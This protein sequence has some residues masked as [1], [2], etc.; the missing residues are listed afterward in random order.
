MEI[1]TLEGLG[2]L[3][4]VLTALVRVLFTKVSDALSTQGELLLTDAM[5]Q[6]LT[7]AK[8]KEEVA[9]RYLVCGEAYTLVRD[10][11]A[12][13]LRGVDSE[14]F[15]QMLEGAR[16]VT[17]T[18]LERSDQTKTGHILGA[19]AKRG[20]EA[21]PE[22]DL[23]PLE[24][25]I[26]RLFTHAA[27][28]LGASVQGQTLEKAVADGNK[29]IVAD[30][31]QGKN[32][33]LNVVYEVQDESADEGDGLKQLHTS[34]AV[35]CYR[36]RITIDHFFRQFQSQVEA[37]VDMKDKFKVIRLFK[38]ESPTLRAL[39]YLPAILDG[40]KRLMNQ[41]HRQKDR[42]E[43][44]ALTIKMVKERKDCTGLDELLE[45]V[46]KAWDIVKDRLITYNCLAP[47]K[48][49][50][51]LPPEF[52]DTSIS[53]NSPLAVLLPSTRGP[54]LC[55]YILLQYLLAAHNHILEGYCPLL[56][57]SDADHTN[58]YKRL[59]EVPVRKISARHLV[60]YSPEGILPLL[61]SSCNYSLQLGHTTTMEYDFEGFQK[62][63]VDTVFQCKSRVQRH[64]DGYFPEALTPAERRE[65]RDDLF[66]D[67]PH[68][69]ESIDHLNTALAFLKA[70]GGDPEGSLHEFMARSL[71]MEQTIHSRKAQQLC[72]LKHVQ[73]LWIL[74]CHERATVLAT[75]NQ[76]A[77][78]EQ[79][80][81]LREPMTEAQEKEL[82]AMCDAMSVDRLELLLVHL[83]ECIM[84][85]LS[86]PPDD[87]FYVEPEDFNLF[88]ELETDLRDVPFYAK[89]PVE[90]QT[91][92]LTADDLTTFKFPKS[93]EG[94]HSTSVWLA[95]RKYLAAKRQELNVATHP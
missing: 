74:L 76:D 9:D 83:F 8:Q 73:S 3:R 56:R 41:L 71:Q 84:L 23:T 70:L 86:Q 60:G 43:A 67:L 35:W 61:L 13:V 14:Q 19:A 7:L 4:Y 52:H 30:K 51:S 47:E 75:Y 94:R 82:K 92:L 89:E 36:P 25:A 33:L 88:E 40:Q 77:F 34:P 54:G 90:I 31:R 68:I 1:V 28:Y 48:E 20:L 93:L 37:S 80:K 18:S 32:Y 12:E 53:V 58:R 21:V 85:R 65:I 22:R 24:C 87:D 26:T 49:V 50:V 44:A 29:A 57:Q 17:S 16:T 79:E 95:C 91:G 64:D 27:L 5:K 46:S 69:C 11:L 42:A 39:H 72:R 81:G 2:R 59:P 10:H 66:R 63:L 15:L 6:L 62:Q 55:S 38:A 78:D 45:N